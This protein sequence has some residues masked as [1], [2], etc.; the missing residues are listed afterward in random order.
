MIST[1]FRIMKEKGGKQNWEGYTWL[2]STTCKFYHKK[3]RLIWQN[4]NTE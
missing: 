3:M 4:A 1:K 2:L